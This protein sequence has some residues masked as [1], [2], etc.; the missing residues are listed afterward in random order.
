MILTEMYLCHAYSCHEIEDGNAWAGWR[1][2]L[3]VDDLVGDVVSTLT[4]AGQ[5]E[6]TY[7]FYSSDQ[8]DIP[9]DRHQ[10]HYLHVCLTTPRVP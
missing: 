8:C 6:N 5:M 7:F 1:T 10:P 4:K 2:L 9:T 3:S